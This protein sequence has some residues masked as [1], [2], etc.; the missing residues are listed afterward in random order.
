MATFFHAKLNN[1]RSHLVLMGEKS[2]EITRQSIESFVNQDPDQA[3]EVLRLDDT[4]D[5]LEVKV[6]RES[7]RYITLLAP[8]ASDLR[9]I[10]TVMKASHD[11]ERIGDEATAIA[12]RTQRLSRKEPCNAEHS[13]A[14]MSE[15]VLQMLRKA[16]DS[17]IQEDLQMAMTIPDMDKEVDRLNKQNYRT[18]TQAVPQ[19]PEC[20]EQL[21]EHIFVSKSV[22]RVGDHAKNLAEEVIFLLSGEDVRHTAEV[23]ATSETSFQV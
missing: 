9:L 19:M 6:D 16:L 23:K 21:V 13:I 18:L 17:F 3:A 1:I 15:I 20:A 8:V 14:E 22:E 11:L 10:T 2:V 12:K 4:I 5:E 7:L